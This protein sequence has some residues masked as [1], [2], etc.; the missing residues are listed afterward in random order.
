MRILHVN[1]FDT[2]GGAAKAAFRLYDALN[3]ADIH[4]QMLVQFKLSNNEDILTETN[5]LIIVLN[6][7]SS[8]LD[9]L[10][11]RFFF[12]NINNYSAAF[13][14]SF[15]IV[16]KINE[17]NPDI[18]H[19]HWICNGMIA[20][21]DIPKIKAPI[22]WSMHD[23]WVLSGGCH[24]LSL[25][26][27][28]QKDTNECNKFLNFVHIRKRKYFDQK[29]DMHFNSLSSWLYQ[30][31]LNSSL[32]GN[33]NN[34]HLPNLINTKIFTPLEKNKSRK[35][36]N[37]PLNKKILLFGALNASRDKNKGFDLLC[38]SLAKLDSNLI[39]IV[40]FGQ[41]NND[42]ISFGNYKFHDLGEIN[43]EETLNIVLNSGDLLVVPS[44]QENLS[45]LILESL[46][47]SIPVVAFNVGGNKDL[48]SHLSN[49]YLAKP[50]DTDDLKN[51]IEWIVNYKNPENL[52][53]NARNKAI[54]DFDSNVIA[55]RYIDLYKNIISGL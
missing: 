41:K 46:S 48:I 16:N 12:K 40:I 8:K 27:N 7:I 51:G 52:K 19:F 49:G 30:L 5:P 45:N 38:E 22:L 20:I 6:K 53:I 34:H 17:L 28:H 42:S 24:N 11:G 9:A 32:I 35:L 43:D 13:F 25:C 4:S 29:P 31:S 33:R 2:K 47:A 1:S 14:S 36:T 10:I 3:Q 54:K 23:N 44:I 37:L 55:T 15:N 26:K 39:E 50:F 21:E 18:V